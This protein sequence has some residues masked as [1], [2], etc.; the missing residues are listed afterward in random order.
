MFN[1]KNKECQEVFKKETEIN[2][3]LLKC[4]ENE[5]PIEIQSKKWLKT[6]NSIL[7]K[8]FRKVRICENRKKTDS[9]KNNLIRERINLKKKSKAN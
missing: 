8:C 4:F 3:D 6:F 9:Q 5:L 1:L 2:A 7:H